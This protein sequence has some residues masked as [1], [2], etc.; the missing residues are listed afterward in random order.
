MHSYSKSDA[1]DEDSNHLQPSPELE[2]AVTPC[3][4]ENA[5]HHLSGTRSMLVV[6][7][8]R[9]V[10]EGPLGGSMNDGNTTP[11]TSTAP[12]QVNTQVFIK[13]GEPAMKDMIGTL[14]STGKFDD[15]VLKR[16]R[17]LQKPI[18]NLQVVDSRYGS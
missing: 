11:S 2:F 14:L 16:M 18:I 6:Q 8:T 5:P 10:P 12:A 1:D 7:E 3:P 13:G 15:L 4:G 9:K 17:E